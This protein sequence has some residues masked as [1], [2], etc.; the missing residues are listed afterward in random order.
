MNIYH[1]LY[2]KIFSFLTFV[3]R[4][5]NNQ[6]FSA[7]IGITFLVFLNIISIDNIVRLNY[8]DSNLALTRNLGIGL[9]IV[10]IIVNWFFLYKGQKYKKIIQKYS[11]R[12]DAS[13]VGSF[14]VLSYLILTIYC[15][16]HFAHEIRE[17]EHPQ[18]IFN[19]PLP[20]N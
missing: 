16:F 4:K 20:N 3:N 7:L 9:I 1:Y 6:E 2:Y 13:S 15:F 12:N 14:L 18:N 5:D 17:L 11:K 8:P 19:N 10:L